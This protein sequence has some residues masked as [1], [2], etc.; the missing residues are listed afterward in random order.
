MLFAALGQRK[1]PLAECPPRSPSYGRRPTIR[2]ELIE[3]LDVLRERGSPRLPAHRPSGV[4]PDPQPRD[5][6][7]V[8]N[9]RGI[10]ACSNGVAAREPRGRPVGRRR[11]DRLASSS[12]STRPTRTTRRRPGIRTTRSR[13]RCS[14][15]S[16]SRGPRRH[17][18]TGQRYINHVARGS[19]V[20]LFVR[21]NRRD[22]RGVALRISASAPRATSATSPIGRCRSSGSSSGRC[23]PRSTAMRRSPPGSPGH[24][25]QPEWCHA[26]GAVRLLG[27]M[28]VL[29][30]SGRR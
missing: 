15:G 10:R 14:T 12:H 29:G 20:V 11:T 9:H 6:R 5:I 23:P 3:L 2:E 26:A 16:L 21:E 13:Q 28:N 17:S 27:G 19:R 25:V 30:R 22:E 4:D 18:P 8:R 24:G 7:P 1:R